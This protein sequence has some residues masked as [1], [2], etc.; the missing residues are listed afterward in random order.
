MCTE[1]IEVPPCY[2]ISAAMDGLLWWLIVK[3]VAR[4]EENCTWLWGDK[5]DR[6]G[7]GCSL[8]C[9]NLKRR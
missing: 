9:Y 8:L 1:D 4:L 7:A 5:S 2:Q 6:S 3:I